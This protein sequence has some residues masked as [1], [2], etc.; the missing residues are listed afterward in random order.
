MSE[1]ESHHPESDKREQI[2]FEI[3]DVLIYLVRL[4]DLLGIDVLSEAAAKI[5][6]E[7]KKYPVELSRGKASK[8]AD[9]Q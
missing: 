4:A 6:L 7:E 3:A 8:Y 1:A 5:A 9:Y 2:A